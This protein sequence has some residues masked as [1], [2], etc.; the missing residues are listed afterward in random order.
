V[1]DSVSVS[2]PVVQANHG[3][4]RGAVVRFDGSNWVLA[5]TGVA[6]CGLVGSITDNNVFE[7]VQIGRLEGLSGLT[8]GTSYFPDSTGSLSSAPNGTA[9]G[10]AY[11]DQS[12]FVQPVAQSAAGFDPSGFATTASLVQATATEVA[13]ANAA[14]AT[15]S[16][17]HDTV[18]IHSVQHDAVISV[19]TTMPGVVFLASDGTQVLTG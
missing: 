18:Y 19:D 15:I 11:D 10:I 8:P 13:R 14:Y 6:G 17:N 1:A 3:F 4:S 16:H 12:I 7:F 2:V 9:V 5:T